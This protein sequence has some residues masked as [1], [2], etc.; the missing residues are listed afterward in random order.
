M[1]LRMELS[2]AFRGNTILRNF[3]AS[4]KIFNKQAYFHF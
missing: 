4:G 2:V 3:F 1:I